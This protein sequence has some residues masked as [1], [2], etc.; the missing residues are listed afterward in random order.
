[1]S[2]AEQL[3]QKIQSLESHLEFKNEVIKT[4]EYLI[5][6]LKDNYDLAKERAEALEQENKEL[7]L[8][9]NIS[10]N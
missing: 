8:F 3:S 5:S 1:M 2:K 4:K 6:L 7:L 9:R 10:F